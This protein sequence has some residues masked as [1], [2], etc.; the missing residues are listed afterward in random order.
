MALPPGPRVPAVLS[1]VQFARR[2]LDTLLRWQARYGN[3]FTVTFTGFGE[4]VYVADPD[5]IRELFCGDQADLH[6]G[7]ANAILSPIVGDRSVLVLDGPEH[8]RQRKLLLPPFNG[9]R[10]DAAP[11]DHDARRRARGRH[12][13]RRRDDRPAQPHA[14]ADL[15]HH[16]PRRL[17]RHRP[18]QD[19]PVAR[20][21]CSP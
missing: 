1:T 5:A 16:Q 9:A 7:E 18:G 21:R 15:R 2:P 14:V 10:V 17:R 13:A 11:L 20:L 3:V 6:A 4:G 19:R 8:L 12:V